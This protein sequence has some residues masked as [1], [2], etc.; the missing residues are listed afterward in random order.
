MQRARYPYPVYGAQPNATYSLGPN[1][2][3]VISNLGNLQPPSTLNAQFHDYEGQDFLDEIYQFDYRLKYSFGGS[4]LKNIR[5]GFIRCLWR[6]GSDK[7]SKSTK[8]PLT[9]KHVCI[10]GRT[11]RVH[12]LW[13][14]DEDS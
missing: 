7:S 10:V 5:S 6:K 3:P 1:Y 2:L 13:E 12:D 8:G 11:I 9:W 4:F 14:S